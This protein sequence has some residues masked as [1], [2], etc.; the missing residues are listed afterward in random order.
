MH[1]SINW[2][3]YTHR[4][5]L[6][7]RKEWSSDKCNNMN[8]PWWHYTNWKSRTPRPCTVWFHLYEM[9]RIGKSIK[10]KNRLNGCQGLE[11]RGNRGRPL[12]D[13]ESTVMKMFWYYIIV[14]V[15]QLCEYTKI[16]WIKYFKMVTVD[17]WQ[18]PTQF[19]KALP[20][21]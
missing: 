14:L 9:S 10:R 18:K 20:S 2:W 11:G 4:M 7:H 6:S 15:T 8:E 1:M 13:T 17:I 21:N 12:I 16:P 19:N 3:M 5:L